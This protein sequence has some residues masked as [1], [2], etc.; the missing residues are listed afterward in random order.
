[1]HRKADDVS[2]RINVDQGMVL[3]RGGIN[4]LIAAC[5]LPFNHTHSVLPDMEDD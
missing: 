1:M 4:A 2:A 3:Q 5:I